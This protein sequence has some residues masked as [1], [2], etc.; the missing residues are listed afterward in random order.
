MLSIDTNMLFHAFNEDPQ[1]DIR[2]RLAALLDR[3]VRWRTSLPLGLVVPGGCQ[4]SGPWLA[5][6]PGHVGLRVMRFLASNLPLSLRERKDTLVKCLQAMGQ[7]RRLR[8][9]YLFGS[10]ALGE[11]R[12]DSDVDLCI[13][14]DGAERQ[15][16]PVE[17]LLGQV[18]AK[19]G[20]APPQG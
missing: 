17:R 3:V 6:H 15:V 7:V 19:L 2:T 4:S 20:R 12:P 8:A 11:A 9:V 10:H 14:A 1:L 13:V 18:K 5:K 16:Q